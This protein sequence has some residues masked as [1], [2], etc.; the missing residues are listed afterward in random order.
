MSKPYDIDNSEEEPLTYDSGMDELTDDEA[1][2]MLIAEGYSYDEAKRM[3]GLYDSDDDDY[4]FDD[5]DRDI[6]DFNDDEDHE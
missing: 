2:E 3:V 4:C 5:N 6:P 1:I